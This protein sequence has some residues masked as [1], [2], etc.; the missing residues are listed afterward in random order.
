MACHPFHQQRIALGEFVQLQSFGFR[1][2]RQV[3]VAFGKLGDQFQRVVFP[4]P[5]EADDLS[6]HVGAA[7]AG[8]DRFARARQAL[9][10]LKHA[11][12]LLFVERFEVVDDNQRV[13]IRQQA[14][15]FV[16]ALSRI[17]LGDAL[18]A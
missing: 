11:P 2:A 6:R 16:G 18:V 3:P 9:Q 4:Q 14:A 5:I 17:D 10:K 7:A 12:A 15:R 13:A 8:D 1:C